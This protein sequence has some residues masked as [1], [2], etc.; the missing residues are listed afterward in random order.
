VARLAGCGV[1]RPC[2]FAGWE[3]APFTKMSSIG[4]RGASTVC[5]IHEGVG[6]VGAFQNGARAVSLW[7]GALNG[8]P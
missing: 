4:N 8:L 1:G 5:G 7:L 2:G 3:A 6:G